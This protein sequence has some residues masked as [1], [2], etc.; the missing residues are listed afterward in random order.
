[1]RRLP[2]LWAKHLD[3]VDAE[4]REVE[5]ETPFGR[6]LVDRQIVV[7]DGVALGVEIAGGCIDA[8]LDPARVLGTAE[9]QA[10]AD[11]LAGQ[12]KLARQVLADADPDEAGFAARLAAADDIEPA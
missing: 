11:I 9:Q 10:D 6:C 3:G 1:M 4:R 12:P 8:D 5:R 2:V 7:A